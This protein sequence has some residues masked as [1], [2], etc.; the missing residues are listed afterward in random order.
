MVPPRKMEGMLVAVV[1]ALSLTEWVP[2][3]WASGEPKTLELLAETPINCLL[4]EQGAWSAEFAAQAAGRGVV[5]LGVIRPS[6]EPLQ[7]ARRAIQTKLDG[8]V[9]EGEFDRALVESIRETLAAARPVIVELP[10]RRLLRLDGN[11]PIL[12]TYQG[13]WPGIRVEPGGAARAR[14]TGGPWIETNSGFLRFVSTLTDAPVWIA[15][16]PPKA[17]VLPV[18]RYLHAI[19]DAAL[20]GARWVV[21]LDDDFNR[22]LLAGDAAALRDW[23]RIGGHLRYF[24]EHKQWRA[25]KPYSRLALVQDPDVRAMLSGGILDMIGGKNIPVRPISRP[26]LDGESLKGAKMA[27][28]VEPAS[29]TEAQKEVLKNVA[30]AGGA[31]LNGPPGWKLPFPKDSEITLEKDQLDKVNDVWQGINSV[32]GRSNVGARLFNVSGMLSSLLACADGSRVVLHLVN[33]TNYPVESITVHLLGKYKRAR[34]YSPERPV[35]ELE[36][37][38]IDEGVGVDIDRV[39]VCATLVLE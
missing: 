32:I 29:L 16:L 28:T 12:G 6:A 10:P 1:L 4:L 27:V 22:R 34:L 31:L 33:Y 24:E 17:T 13:V 7:A 15:N 18:D 35:R 5:T 37:Y 26:K 14:P 36:L 39:S 8:V 9:L 21:A 23:R 30:R 25:L 38:P 19:S 3:R 11:A 20:S 2:A